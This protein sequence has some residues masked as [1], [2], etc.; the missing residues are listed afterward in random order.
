MA[1]QVKVKK[2]TSVRPQDNVSYLAFN[3]A[4]RTRNK[5]KQF[6]VKSHPL[7]HLLEKWSLRPD[8]MI[9]PYDVPKDERWVTPCIIVET[10]ECFD[11]MLKHIEMQAEIAIKVQRSPYKSY[12]DYCACVLQLSTA[13]QDFVIDTFGLYSEIYRLKPMFENP[14]VLKVFHSAAK[15]LDLLQL[16]WLIFPI[17]IV[18]T[19]VILNTLHGKEC[20]SFYELVEFYLPETKGVKQTTEINWQRRPLNHELMCREIKFTHLLIRAWHAIKTMENYNEHDY[21]WQMI[22][23]SAK[24]ISKKVYSFRLLT[25]EQC[26][27][28]FPVPN[29]L[30]SL[31]HDLHSWRNEYAREQDLDAEWV[32]PTARIQQVVMNPPQSRKDLHHFVSN[33][34]LRQSELDQIL[35]IIKIRRLEMPTRTWTDTKRLKS[36]VRVVNSLHTTSRNQKSG[37]TEDL[38]PSKSNDDINSDELIL[39]LEQ[40]LLEQ[41]KR[42]NR[43][44]EV[45]DLDILDIHIQNSDIMDIDTDMKNSDLVKLPKEKTGGVEWPCF[46]CFEFGHLRPTCPYKDKD[47][48]SSLEV[49]DLIRRNKSS[50]Y[51]KNP[52]MKVRSRKRRNQNYAESLRKRARGPNDQ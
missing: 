13:T 38:I 2:P 26:I 15:D 4:V 52:E 17:G 16:Q 23:I 34:R 9:P 5:L 21:Q 8:R 40:E 33:P 51:A 47:A 48:R 29:R 35:S 42:S 37:H 46:L 32:L 24:E 22:M 36:E 43:Q 12:L 27:A 11:N 41:G 44:V 50:F 3:K 6:P 10:I 18:D 7:S 39:S 28:L 30:K 19:E 20:A 45:V 31:F 25:F 1:Y 49:Q 14:E